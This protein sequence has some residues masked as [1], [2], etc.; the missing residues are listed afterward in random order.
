M[1]AHNL[2][3]MSHPCNLQ[4]FVDAQGP[5]YRDVL[6]EL[7]AGIKSSHWMW[8]TFPQLKELGHSQIA[9]RYGIASLPEA[10]AY[11]NHPVLGPRHSLGA[12]IDPGRALPPDGDRSVRGG[13]ERGQH[14]VA[15][16]YI[17]RVATALGVTIAVLMTRARR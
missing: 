16:I 2:H 17:H 6:D 8:I 10:I 4:R 15:L 13:I 3:A 1:S 9:K 11:L 7:R 14:N 12:G 5:I